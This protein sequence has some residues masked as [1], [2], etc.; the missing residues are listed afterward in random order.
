M[1]PSDWPLLEGFEQALAMWT[2]YDHPLDYPDFWVVRRWFV[3]SGNPEPVADV[4]PR[5]A[6]S[7]A[8]ARSLVPKGLY[9]LHRQEGDDPFVVETWL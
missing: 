6:S 3:V 5:I 7:L 4:L 8:E 2:I 1:I 9:R